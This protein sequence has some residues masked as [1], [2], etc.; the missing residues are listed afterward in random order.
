MPRWPVLADHLIVSKICPWARKAATSTSVLLRQ[1]NRARHKPASLRLV[2]EATAAGEE[3]PPL[4]QKMRHTL[5]ILLLLAATP[6][7][8]ADI[9][10][11]H[12]ALAA[13]VSNYTDAQY[14]STLCMASKVYQ[15]AA[16]TGDHEATSACMKAME[17]MMP[18]F[19]RRFPGRK[20]HE[21]VGRCE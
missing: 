19:A 16:K 21:V 20:P 18:D 11:C 14:K 6:V 9:T 3:L 4:S 15:H 17:K 5:A 10:L 2:L 8:A 13:D 7:S 12:Q 1:Q